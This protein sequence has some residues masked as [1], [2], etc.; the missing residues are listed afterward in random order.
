M[1]ETIRVLVADDHPFV[2]QGIAASLAHEPDI[3]LVGEV[4]DGDEALRLCQER[5]ADVLLLD[6]KMPGLPVLEVIK[7]LRENRSGLP[8]LMLTAQEDERS[9]R[10]TLQAGAS[11]YMLKHEATQVLAQAIRTVHTGGTWLSRAATEALV[12]PPAEAALLE[13][14]R[15]NERDR[16]LLR[17]IARGWDTARIGAELH[18][19]EQTVRNYSSRLYQKLGLRSREEAIVWAQR[20]GFGEEGEVD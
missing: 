7:A 3:L 16:A 17:L 12:Q 13:D 15:L 8:I 19:A 11:G 2:R 1:T 4:R 20:H 14:E 18:L 10:S 5:A 9:I 6:L